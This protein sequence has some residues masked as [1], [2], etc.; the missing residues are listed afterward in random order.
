M[1]W[2]DNA[3]PTHRAVLLMADQNRDVRSYSLTGAS[4]TLSGVESGAAAFLV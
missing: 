3:Y 4:A 2:K 1:G